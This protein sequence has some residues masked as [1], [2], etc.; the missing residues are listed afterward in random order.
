MRIDSNEYT[1]PIDK[2]LTVDEL[3]VISVLHDKTAGIQPGS[4]TAALILAIAAAHTADKFMLHT[5]EP[6]LVDAVNAWQ[7]GNLYERFT[8]QFPR[9][10]E[11]AEADEQLE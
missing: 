8:H 3:H 4:F 9:A 10:V 7:M 1:E 5:I 11:V 6:D 2:P